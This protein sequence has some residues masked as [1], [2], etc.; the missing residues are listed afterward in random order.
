MGDVEVWG[1]CGMEVWCMGV[2]EVVF[3]VRARLMAYGCRGGEVSVRVYPV[4]YV[5]V[6]VWRMGVV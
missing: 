2:M 3:G 6:Y 5:C 1:M 4:A